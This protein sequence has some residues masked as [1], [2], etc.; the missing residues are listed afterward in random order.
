MKDKTKSQSRELNVLVRVELKWLY[1]QGRT[2]N[3]VR[4]E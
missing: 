4:R 2:G 3:G 1:K